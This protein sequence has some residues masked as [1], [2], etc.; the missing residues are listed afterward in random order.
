MSIISLDGGG[1][2]AGLS[3][4]GWT[5]SH[6]A[7]DT[8]AS[9]GKQPGGTADRVLVAAAA[10]VPESTGTD[11]EA[12]PPP[13]PQLRPLIPAK[14]SEDALLALQRLPD[15]LATPAGLVAAAAVAA[16][17]GGG[18]SGAE[19][20]VPFTIK[21]RWRFKTKVAQGTF[22]AVCV[23]PCSRDARC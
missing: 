10:A 5:G 21:N 9:A 22:G 8:A 7:S 14:D 6:R 2:G 17:G 19:V 11:P 12:P 13:S 20:E 1:A 18:D 15:A 23:R 4:G 3:A 16:G